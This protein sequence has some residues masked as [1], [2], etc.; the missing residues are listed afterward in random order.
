MPYLNAVVRT[1]IQMR[2][3]QGLGEVRWQSFHRNCRSHGNSGPGH[4]WPVVSANQ[5]ET[6]PVI[7]LDDSE[8]SARCQHG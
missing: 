4:T 6:D 8:A 5:Q 7:D 1:L 2:L 3:T